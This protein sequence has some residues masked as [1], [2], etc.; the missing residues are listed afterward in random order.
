MPNYFVIDAG[1]KHGPFDD[2]QLKSLAAKGRITPTT[3]LETDSGH[4]GQ[5]GQIPGL[6]GAAQTAQAPSAP[7]QLFCTNCGKPVSDQAIACMSC[8]AKPAG[9]RKFCRQCASTLSPEQVVCTK[10]GTGVSGAPFHARQTQAAANL[11]CTNC[12][13]SNAA[14]AVACMSCGAKPTGHKKFCR[15]CGVGLSPEQVVCVKCGA[16]IAAG[17]QDVVGG[18]AER[19]KR[20]T[21]SVDVEKVKKIAIWGGLTVVVLLVL[22]YIIS[23]FLVGPFGHLT[24]ALKRAKQGDKVSY[25]V[26]MS[27]SSMKKTESTTLYHKNG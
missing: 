27:E 15:Q 18:L 25:E 26:T 24:Y 19:A 9:H 12:G 4:Q 22:W 6:F 10:C 2:L 23:F 5:A 13:N 7:K 16:N 21:G 14:Q 20:V 1:Q 8:G 11:F 3:T 17:I